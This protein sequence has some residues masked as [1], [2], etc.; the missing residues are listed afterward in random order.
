MIDKR[1]NDVVNNDRKTIIRQH[2]IEALF[3]MTSNHRNLIYNKE[4][5]SL[6]RD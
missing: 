4:I 5:N 2:I 1:L 3:Y 6:I